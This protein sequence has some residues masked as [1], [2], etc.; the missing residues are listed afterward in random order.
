MTEH[1]YFAIWFLE[2]AA[3]VGLAQVQPQDRFGW[4]G[5]LMDNNYIFQEN[6]NI[7]YYTQLKVS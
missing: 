6:E 7:Y 4:V 2:K 5:T 1:Y 3:H